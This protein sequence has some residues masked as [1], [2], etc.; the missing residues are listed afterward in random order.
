[1]SR[2]ALSVC[3]SSSRAGLSPP[4][5]TML[6]TRRPRRVPNVHRTRRQREQGVVAAAADVVAGVEV[7]AALADD[8]LAGVD[9]LAAEPLDAQPLAVG[10][11]PVP[12]RSWRPSCVP[13]ALPTSLPLVD[14]GDPDPGQLLPVTL[15]LAVAGLVLELEDLDLRALGRLDDLGGDRD[16]GQRLGVAGDV[17]HRPRAAAAAAARCCPASPVEPVDGQHVADGHLLLPA[18]GADDRVHS[19]LALCS[20]IGGQR[21]RAG[22]PARTTCGRAGT[23]RRIRV[24]HRRTGQVKPRPGPTAA[25]AAGRPSTPQ[26]HQPLAAAASAGHA[27]PLPPPPPPAA[28]ARRR[29]DASR[30]ARRG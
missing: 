7:R 1:M 25:G 16:R 29:R 15:P 27:D 18:T 13:S 28:A 6:T 12:G 2:P 11:A 5:G 3:R 22:A 24:L 23:H 17:G 9:L 19:Q 8:D 20:T 4:A 30:P 26:S 10:V 14:A 21:L